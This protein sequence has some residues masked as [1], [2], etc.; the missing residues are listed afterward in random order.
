MTTAKEWLEGACAS[1]EDQEWL[2][3][4]G[5]ST[6]D[7]EKI[8]CIREEILF[9]MS[10]LI[11]KFRPLAIPEIGFDPFEEEM[12]LR[13]L[14]TPRKFTFSFKRQRG[15]G[16]LY[17]LDHVHLRRMLFNNLPNFLRVA[18]F[19]LKA[20]ENG[21]IETIQNLSNK[22]KI[23]R[24]PNW[25]DKITNVKDIGMGHT[26]YVISCDAQRWVIKKE[27]SSFQSFYNH[28]LKSLSY[29]TFESYSLVNECGSWEL[30][31]FIGVNTLQDI[32]K[33]G[34]LSR[35]LEEQLA[36]HCCLGDI[37]GRGDRH[38]ENYIVKNDVIYPID[39][40]FLFWDDN[41][42]WVQ[43]YLKGG[44]SELSCLYVDIETPDIFKFHLSVFYE[45]YIK[46][47]KRFQMHKERIKD[48]ISQWGFESS[49]TDHHL[50]FVE[51]NLSDE[52][53]CDRQF[54]QYLVSFKSLCKRQYFKKLLK[55]IFH[56][57]P[58]GSAISP[59]LKMY[60]YSDRYR[61]SSFF[62]L[63]YLDREHLFEEIRALAIQ[64]VNVSENEINRTL[65]SID[66]MSMD[67]PNT[68]LKS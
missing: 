55:Q 25:I 66:S 40:S 50:R 35:S 5:L 6:T 20:K 11:E 68:T 2:S 19:K 64:H 38:F 9:I 7:P 36:D 59:L 53:F 4:L 21:L 34:S 18:L 31:E 49:E 1:D 17:G 27:R 65:A 24:D 39:V 54:K 28:L 16:V 44:M 63:D 23:F 56:C 33:Q 41:E 43:R 3:R 37:V 26:L 32:I 60:Y 8:Q 62:L 52:S 51:E 58:Q 30:S 42:D 15:E 46:S 48:V 29:T 61:M 10:E 12:L 14:F 45:Q 67:I 22:P 47:F 57:L 13:Y